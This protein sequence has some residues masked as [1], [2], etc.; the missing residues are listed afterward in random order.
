MSERVSNEQALADSRIGR[1]KGRP[2]KF[3]DDRPGL[4]AYALD[5]LD[6][7]RERDEVRLVLEAARKQQRHFAR[8]IGLSGQRPRTATYT[9]L[10]ERTN[11]AIRAYDAARAAKEENNE[12]PA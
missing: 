10:C 12:T 3:N 5:L 7:R 4:R 1:G 2:F 6:A 9:V 11:A 8:M